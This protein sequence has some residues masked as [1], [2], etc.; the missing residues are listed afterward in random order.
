MILYNITLCHII[1]YYTYIYIIRL[2]ARETPQDLE[3]SEN[4]PGS[5]RA[6]AG[7]KLP[8]LYIARETPQDLAGHSVRPRPLRQDA[9]GAHICI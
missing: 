6:L 1:M 7:R 8:I 9:R 5:G 2:P 4:F 3:N